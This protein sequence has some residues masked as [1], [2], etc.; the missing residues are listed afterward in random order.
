MAMP[1]D[2]GPMTKAMT[3][4]AEGEPPDILREWYKS[5]GGPQ[6]VIF[7]W[8]AATKAYSWFES[9]VDLGEGDSDG[10][11][12]AASPTSVEHLFAPLA[13]E[14]RVRIMQALYGGGLTPSELSKTTGFKGGGLYHHLKELKYAAYVREEKGTYLLTYLG[15]MMLITGTVIASRHVVDREEE[16]LDAAA[17]WENVE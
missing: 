6:G 2:L 4:G 16:G 15:R 14:G 5:L 11:V 1:Q 10:V 9:V 12:Q 8:M 7:F 17:A 3:K 13:H